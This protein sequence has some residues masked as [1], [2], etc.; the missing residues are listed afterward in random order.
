MAQSNRKSNILWHFF[1]SVKLT[2]V[3]LIILAVLSIL[4]TI[5]P[6]KGQGAH[7]FARTLTPEL[8][9]LFKSLNLFDMYH[10]LWFRLII[11]CLALNLIIC[12]LDRLP[13]TLKL[14]RTPSRPDRNRP[15]EDLP[16][17]QL[18]VV[19]ENR[20]EAPDRVAGLLRKRY[21]AVQEKQAGENHFFY[22]TKGGYSRFGFYFVHLSILII[23]AGALVGSFSG[24]EAY[25]EIVEG[26]KR[27]TAVLRDGM[28][29]IKL[30]FDVQ[31]DKFSLDVYDNGMPREYRSDLTFII[32]GRFVKKQS[33]IVN[34]PAVFM[35]ISFYQS[36]YGSVPSKDV[37]IRI[38]RPDSPQGFITREVA[39]G[40]VY[41]M[42]DD[43][44]EFQVLDIRADLMRMGPA[45]LIAVR[46]NEKEIMRF[47]VFQ[48]WEVAKERL[49][50]PMAQSLMFNPSAFKPYTFI[51]DKLE[52][53]KYTVLQVNRDP[54][55]PI[56]WIGCFLMV[57]GFFVTFF[58]FH[59]RIWIRVTL[60]ERATEIAVAG[61]SNKNQVALQNELKHLTQEL[62]NLMAT[63]ERRHA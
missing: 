4:G 51:L 38:R 36:S 2:I 12:S 48:N 31:L 41:P 62:K 39:R 56:V 21:R 25:M 8:F 11:G 40:G 20:K 53:R 57:A 3:L 58:M 50:G 17:E 63:M 23:L 37:R 15:F 45:V 14:I 46:K 28:G 9:H 24:F 35:G 49:P 30:G 55:V 10:S 1:K 32:D 18:L 34:D 29:S 44:G 52:T 33:V 22:V 16:E 27:D 47:W 43:D 7:E 59:R 54:G 26:E 13:G 5:I 19:Q 61:T 6:Q 42:A 60:K